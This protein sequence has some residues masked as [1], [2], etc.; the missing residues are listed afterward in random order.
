MTIAK[1][2]G[3]KTINFSTSWGLTAAISAANTN[4][5]CGSLNEFYFLML[6]QSLLGLFIEKLNTSR[7]DYILCPFE[8]LPSLAKMPSPTLFF[9]HIISPHTPYLF[10]RDGNEIEDARNLN[11]HELVNEDPT[12]YLDQLIFINKKVI[13]LVDS[14][15]SNSE[16][17]P[18][19]VIQSD[20][21]SSSLF[22]S[23]DNW[24]EPTT[25]MLNERMRILNLYHVPPS[26]ESQLYSG[27]SPVNSFRVIYNDLF[28]LNLPLLPDK[29]YYSSY[30]SGEASATYHDV[31][32]KVSGPLKAEKIAD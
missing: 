29:S 22:K 28:N 16:T 7:R 6:R 26:I 25:P 24:N 21:G 13:T 32:E 12:M 5:K 8:R 18:I 23:E 17:E 10:D 14:I 31:T 30:F 2:H 3:Y 15:L 9:V 20:H 27:I 4:I 19:I 11:I 1:D